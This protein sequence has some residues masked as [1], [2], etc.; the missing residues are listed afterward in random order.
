MGI[1]IAAPLAFVFFFFARAPD[2]A[3]LRI[4]GFAC[5]FYFSWQ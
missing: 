1:G 4:G 5:C 2:T 3:W